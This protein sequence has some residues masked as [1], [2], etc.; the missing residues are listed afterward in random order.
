MTNWID[1]LKATVI[2]DRIAAYRY[3]AFLEC[4][5]RAL[6]LELHPDLQPGDT[7]P[8]PLDDQVYGLVS[9]GSP[10][11]RAASVLKAIGI[12]PHAEGCWTGC[13]EAVV[14]AFQRPDSPDD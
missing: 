13:I 6:A 5:R 2:R 1:D 14:L 12:T 7:F 3:L 8:I 4:E 11:G 9:K 10:L